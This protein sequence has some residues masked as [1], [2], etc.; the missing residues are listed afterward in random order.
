[1]PAAPKL[2]AAYV[3]RARVILYLLLLA[4]AAV[5]LFGIPPLE[6]AARQ[7]R[8]SPVALIVAPA[9]LVLFVA[10]YA[11]YRFVLVR[12][13]RYPAGNAFVQVGFM[14]L[15]LGLLLPASVERYRAAGAPQALDLHGHL[16][17]ADA[18][19]RAMAA[20]LA[21]HRDRAEALTYVP[22]LVVLLEDRSPEVRRQARASLAAIAGR[23]AGGEGEGAPRRWREYWESQGVAFPRR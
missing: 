20:E 15:A 16:G 3:R 19:A 14:V 12:A 22:R 11:A 5:T 21:R 4:S 13:G 9:V 7:G 18:D 23:D 8:R 10:V 6:E 2:P 1:M 17:S